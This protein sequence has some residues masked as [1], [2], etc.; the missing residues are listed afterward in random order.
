MAHWI[1]DD[2]GFGG[3]IHTCSNCR[4][5]WNDLFHPIGT[6]EK[7]PSCHKEI[8][9]Y[10]DEYVEKKPIDKLANAMKKFNYI[11]NMQR[12]DE[13]IHELEMVSGMSLEELIEKFAAGWT[14]KGPDYKFDMTLLQ[15]RGVDLEEIG[16]CAPDK[17]RPIYNL[18]IDFSKKPEE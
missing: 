8:D 17:I 4:E 1:I 14:L 13:S 15:C 16:S 3:R 11:Q 7:C 6:W 5:V 12:M 18:E 10:K 9:R 2:K